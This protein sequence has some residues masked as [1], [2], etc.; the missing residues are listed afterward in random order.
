MHTGF[1]R[2][3]AIGWFIA[4]GVRRYARQRGFHRCVIRHIPHP[5]EAALW[6]TLTTSSF[7][8][9]LMTTG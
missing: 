5:L 4:G 7:Y 6:P 8:D 2:G 9:G 3:F 1:A